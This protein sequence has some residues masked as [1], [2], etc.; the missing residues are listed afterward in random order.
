MRPANRIMIP[1]ALGPNQSVAVG[2]V[3]DGDVVLIYSRPNSLLSRLSRCINVGGQRLLAAIRHVDRVSLFQRLPSHSHALLGIGGGLV[4]H[5]DGKRV[6]IDVISDVIRPG[7]EEAAHF[8][9]YRHQQ[10]SPQAKAEIVNAA[11]RYYSQSYGFTPYFGSIG[12]KSRAKEDTTQFCSRLVAHAYGAAGLPLT[13]LADKRVLPLDL[14][15][16]CQDSEWRD[17]TAT[18]IEE[19]FSDDLTDLLRDAGV[20]EINGRNPKE[21]F[22]DSEKLIR[23]G[24]ALQRQMLHL[25]HKTLRDQLH[26]Q[27]VIAKFVSLQ[28]ELA[29]QSLLEPDPADERVAGWVKSVLCQLP[30]L[31]DLARLPEAALL[32]DHVPSRMTAGGS[33]FVGMPEPSVMQQIGLNGEV[34]RIFAYLLLANL[35]MLAIASRLRPGDE[36]EKYAALG[37]KWGV[38]W[39]A[40]LPEVDGLTQRLA[41]TQEGFLWVESESDRKIARSMGG[42]I[43]KVLQMIEI[44]SGRAV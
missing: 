13:R 17:V 16:I 21:F 22:A 29:K 30:E 3:A 14:Y 33:A 26:A 10:L 43:I 25:Q 7:T 44:R 39:M 40:A 1:T 34:C 11:Y 5:A 32:V 6:S 9:V 8:A 23:Q 36:F 37:E 38:E 42:S 4:I 19:E 35:G 28:L 12:R 41:D 31:L 2:S 27:A 18:F 20:E 24:A 15:R